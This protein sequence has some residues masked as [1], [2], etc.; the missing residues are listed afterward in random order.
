MKT[1]KNLTADQLRRSILQLAIEGKLVKQNPN[2]EPASEL[3]KKIMAEKKKL[4]QEGKIKKDKNESYIFKGDDNCYYEKIGNNTPVKLEDLPF[5]IPDNWTWIRLNSFANIYNGNSINET[6]KI[7]KYTNV[8][9]RS[10]IATKDV[11]FNRTIDYENGVK[12][13]ENETKFRIAPANKILLCIEGGSAGRKIAFTNKEV[14]FGNKLA[15]FNTFTINDLYLYNILQTATFLELFKSSLTGIIGGV[16]INTLKS[17]LVPL[18][19]LEEQQ[20]I[21]DKICFIEP[22]LEKYDSIEKKL[23]ALETEFPEKL[24]KSILQYAIEGKLVKQDPNDEPASALLERIK[25]EKEKLIK[26]GKIKRDKNE[27]YIY[28]GDDKNYYEKVGKNVSLINMPLLVPSSWSWIK[29]KAI[30][31]SLQYGFNGSG[32]TEGK[33]KMLR[34]TDIQNNSVNWETLPYC[35]ICEDLL[36]DYQISPNDIFIARTGGTIGKSFQ[37]KEDKPKTVFAG[38]L[39]RF[40]FVEEKLSDY[41]SMFLNSPLYWNQVA[42]KQTGTGQPNINGVSLGNLLI[43]VPPVNEQIRIESKIKELFETIS[44]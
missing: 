39:I 7:R 41:V 10:F 8:K 6:E 14:C 12:I 43:P 42:D 2:D 32:L 16:S 36:S 40:R 29:A 26:E 22:L 44:H 15:C 1:I 21:V 20:R 18:P 33:V 19:P 34:I 35:S 4:I 23:S 17:F 25:A 3:V 13:P 9:G 37:L 28:Q 31:K 11:L 38:Y 24:K 30:L 27:S 5:D